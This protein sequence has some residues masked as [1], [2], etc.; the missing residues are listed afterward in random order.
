MWLLGIELRTSGRAAG[1]LNHSPFLSAP[2]SCL[3]HQQNNI[4]INSTQLFLHQ[5]QIR[6]ISDQAE[7]GQH[8]MNRQLAFQIILRQPKLH[9]TKDCKEIC[10][11]MNTHKVTAC[12]REGALTKG[13][14]LHPNEN[15]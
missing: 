12:Q 7:K 9:L 14:I 2:S 5:K 10:W 1:A 8:K 15:Q 6:S 11:T 3:Y 13:G 4:N